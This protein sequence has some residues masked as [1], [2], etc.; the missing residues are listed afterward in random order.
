MA[1]ILLSAKSGSSW[2]DNELTAF[3]I[4]VDTV[5][6]ATF[7]NMEQ[8]PH[9]LVSP[10]I[11]LNERRPQGPLVKDDRLFF[12]YMRDAEKGEESLVDDF[13]A[14]I[15]GMF[16]YDEPERIIHQRKEISFIMCGMEVDAKPDVCVMSESEYLL[17]VQEDKRGTN[18]T[19][20]EPQLIAEAIA[21]FYQNNL[22]RRLAGHPPMNSQ[23]IPGITM[24]GVVPVFY[25]IPITVEL[26]QCVQAGSFP[27]QPTIVQRC[28]PPVPNP[29]AYPDEG[30]VPVTNRVVVMQCFEAFKAFVGA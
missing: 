25:R 30:L 17:L 8:L 4:Q 28:I 23:T 19:D 2:T 24:V 29:D 5:D 10:V 26:V 9:P 12:H 18:R 22:R 14:F 20:P 3:N 27:T 21:A 1:N 7:F 6:A 11:L 13:A 16:G 15:L